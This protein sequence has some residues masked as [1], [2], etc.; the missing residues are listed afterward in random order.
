MSLTYLLKR[1]PLAM[2]AHFDFVLVVTYAFPR[3]VL[4]SCLP[5]G[6]EIDTFGD[7]GFVAVA[8]VQTRNMRP[9]GMPKFISRDYGLIGYRIFVRYKTNEG[10]RLRGLKKMRSD[11]D[12][13]SMVAVGNLLTHYNFQP[14]EMHFEL[15]ENMLAVQSKSKDGIGDFEAV[16]DLSTALAVSEAGSSSGNHLPEGSPFVDLREALKFAGPMPFTFDYERSG[17]R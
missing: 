3:E 17:G 14:A 11:T 1:H 16:A 6:L 10:R 4:Q 13:N 12:H 9:R 2:E 5:P 7:L 8:V 15:G